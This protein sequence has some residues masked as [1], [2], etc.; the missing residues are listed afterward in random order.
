MKKAALT[1]MLCSASLASCVE[2]TQAP[3]TLDALAPPE[4]VGSAEQALVTACPYL[5]PLDP[6]FVPLAF[7]VDY[8]SELMITRVAVV[9]DPCRTTW[10][11]ACAP[12]ATPAIW[13]FGKLM[14]RMAGTVPPQKFVA[15]WLHQWEVPNVVNGFPVPPRPGIRPLVIDPW[16]VASGGPGCFPG[17]PI[18]G[19]GACKLDL[20][21]A[22]FR[23]LAI[24]SR[25]DL[26]CAGYTGMGDPE[27]RF[28]FGFLD[29]TGAPLQAAVILEYKVPALRAGVP[30]TPEQW[31]MDWHKLSAPALAPIGSPPYNAYLESLLN[32]ITAPGAVP[33]GQNLGTSIGQVRTNEIS[34]G[35]G[36]WK[37]R[38]SNLQNTGAGLNA[39]SLLP[40]TTAETPDDSF[41][42]T[43]PALDAYLN[44]NSL[45]FGSP[46]LSSFTQAPLP[47]A[48]SGGESS[49]L[50]P[51]DHTPVTPL[52]P[53]ERHH[54]SFNTCNGCHQPE[55]STPFLHVSNRAAFTPAVLSPFLSQSTVHAGGGMPAG[56]LVVPDPVPTGAVFKY[57]E[58]WRRVCEATRMLSG[59]PVCWSRANGGH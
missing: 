43:A 3:D 59:S 51:W 5:D 50:A 45:A 39:M 28:V 38:E 16:I 36:A 40:T 13:T 2:S 56:A 20:T 17:A 49:V 7:P 22:P 42:P 46:G 57:N 29:A 19:V 14:T 52:L 12:G 6:M 23:L 30:H 32:D 8:A 47:L 33:G 53:I 44:A 10:T 54:F 9:D 15:D 41:N 31:E 37:L 26:E 34:F 4:R 11:G 25:P 21:K 55:T 35:G 48:L 18:V 27:A 24:S 1:L 58:P